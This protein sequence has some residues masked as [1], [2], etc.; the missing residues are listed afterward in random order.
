MTQRIRHQLFLPPAISAQLEALAAKPGT[1]KSVILAD[2][3]TAWLERKGTLELD[4]RFAPR[5]DRMLSAI[6]RVERDGQVLLETLAL[7]VRYE[8]AIHAPLADDDAAGRA[9]GRDR[10]EAFV[11]QVGRQLA[12][13][14]RTLGNI[15]GDP[16]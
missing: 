9:I 1:T 11:I 14:R 4:A 15:G 16:L 8:L 10:F 3:L 5:L 6:G 2:A 7:F 12:S 13:G